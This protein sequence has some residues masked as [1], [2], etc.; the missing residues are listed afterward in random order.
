MRPLTT[1]DYELLAA[2][3]AAATNIGSRKGMGK[4][5]RQKEED[6]EATRKAKVP[7]LYVRTCM[8]VLCL[9]CIVFSVQ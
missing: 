7:N 1:D 6:D 2:Q 3:Q 8:R 9:H 5:R 4:G